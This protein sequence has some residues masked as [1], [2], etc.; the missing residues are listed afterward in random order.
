MKIVLYGIGGRYHQIRERAF[1]FHNVVAVTDS[2]KKSVD[3][4]DGDAKF[5]SPKDLGNIDFDRILITSDKFNDQIYQKLVYECG[6]DKRKIVTSPFVEGFITSGFLKQMSF[7]D[8]KAYSEKVFVCGDSH[9]LFF[10]NASSANPVGIVPGVGVTTDSNNC[11]MVF[12]VGPCLANNLCS[13]GRSTHGHEKINALHDTGLIPGDGEKLICC[14]GEI[15][16]RVHVL[17]QAQEQRATV[18][19]IVD[20]TVDRYAS[21]LQEMSETNEVYVWGPVASLKEGSYRD[22]R[23]PYYGTE[24]ERNKATEY[25]N[26]KLENKCRSIGVKYMSVYKYLMEDYYTKIEYYRDTI[27]IGKKARELAKREFDRV[28]LKVKWEN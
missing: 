15:D 17:M 28:G 9:S 27:H 2:N 23:F 20:D 24:T 4:D 6:V 18:G 12:H 8:S 10:A 21:F 5:V 11:F 3:A 7:I 19:K 26:T 22:P 25:F 14:F 16:I 1:R 13:Y